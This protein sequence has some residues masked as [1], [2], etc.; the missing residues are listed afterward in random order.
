MEHIEEKF[1][2][3][4]DK[5]KWLNLGGGHLMTREGYDIGLLIR[6]LTC[7]R[8]R[9]PNLHLILEPGSAFAWRTGDLVSQVVD[10]GD[11][12]TFEDMIHYTTVKTNMFN[13]IDHPAIVLLHESGQAEVLRSYTY[14]DYRDRMC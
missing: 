2:C 14:E 12:V 13:G 4:L 11:T 8:Q 6:T 1:G 7:F 5:I 3:W 9:H 10:V